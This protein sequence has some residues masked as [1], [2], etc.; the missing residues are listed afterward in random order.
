[1]RIPLF[2]PDLDAGTEPMTVSSWLIDRGDRVLTGDRCVEVLIS[3][4]TFDVEA[5]Q[6]GQLIEIFKPVDASVYP[7]D[8]LGWLHCNDSES[9]V[10]G[11][12]KPI[13]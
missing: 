12:V 3:G 13:A 1:M 7:G 9:A 11:D 6:P 4:V 5:I 10:I 8:V 2:L